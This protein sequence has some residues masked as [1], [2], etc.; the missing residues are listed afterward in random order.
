M[1]CLTVAAGGWVSNLIVYLIQEFNMKSIPAAKVYNVA[2]GCIT[3]FPILA[4]IIADSFLGC[5]SV[6]WISSLISALVKLI[7]FH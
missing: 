5:F 7:P 6:I 1:A 4:G 2:N 3:I